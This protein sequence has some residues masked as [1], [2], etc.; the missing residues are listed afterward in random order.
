[1]NLL[2]EKY[3]SSFLGSNMAKFNE[4]PNSDTGNH[5]IPSARQVLYNQT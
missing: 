4:I 2:S 3:P 1:M 5:N